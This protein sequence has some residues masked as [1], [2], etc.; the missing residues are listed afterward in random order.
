MIIETEEELFFAIKQW[1]KKHGKS[2]IITI[3]VFLTVGVGWFAAV[4]QNNNKLTE[5]SVLYEELL[6]NVH[7]QDSENIQSLANRLITNYS[8]T[9]YS[10]L[11]ALILAKNLAEN[12]KFDSAKKQLRWVMEKS[13]ISAVRQ[14]ARD[15][16]AQILLVENQKK[17]A[18]EVLSTL[19]DP[20]YMPLIEVIKGDIKKASGDTKAALNA[21][22]K[23]LEIWP[24]GFP[25][26]EL[27]KLKLQHLSS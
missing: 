24:V 15:R 2:I 21:Y 13:E 18:L 20:A 7:N 4:R 22:Q 6:T 1:L 8:H 26:K 27:I 17:E 5:A 12:T 9:P 19:D 3:L 23:A 10:K 16:L 25:G 14:I 11:G